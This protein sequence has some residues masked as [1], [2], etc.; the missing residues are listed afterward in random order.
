MFFDKISWFTNESNV[1][2]LYL[3]SV[4]PTLGG[5][6]STLSLVLVA[7]LPRLRGF[8]RGDFPGESGQIRPP[9]EMPYRH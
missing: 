5:T 4:T 7:A 9:E 1:S 8:G 2:T 3:E 6:C